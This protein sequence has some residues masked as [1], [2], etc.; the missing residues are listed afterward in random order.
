MARISKRE[1]KL[2]DQAMELINSDKE[3]TFEEKEFCFEN[4]KGDGTGFN[5]AFFTPSGLAWDFSIDAC[6]TGNVLELCA[7]IG[8]LAFCVYH[9]HKPKKIVCVELNTEYARIGQRLLP[10]AEWVVGDALEYESDI[11]FDLVMGNPPFGKIKTSTQN[12]IF[13]YKGNEF[14]LKIAA[15]GKKFAPV[16]VFIVPQMS[17]GFKYSGNPFYDNSTPSE[18]YIRWNKETGLIAYPGVGID[19][20]YY[21]EQ[22][23]GTNIICEVIEVRYHEHEE[24]KTLDFVDFSE[25]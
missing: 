23:N 22:W 14:E 10:E 8:R 4:Y 9:R 17:S 11:K 1:Q 3:L 16:G 7:G 15:Y 18:K 24:T 25:I 13:G 2:H 6:C 20:S 5:G 12:N 21:S 19:T